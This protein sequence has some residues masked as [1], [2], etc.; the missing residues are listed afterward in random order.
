M[1]STKDNKLEKK[2]VIKRNKVLKTEQSRKRRAENKH[3]RDHFKSLE[4]G[5]KFKLVDGEIHTY[6]DEKNNVDHLDKAMQYQQLHAEEVITYAEDEHGGQ[7]GTAILG[8]S[9]FYEMG[10]EEG[11]YEYAIEPKDWLF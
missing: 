10:G 3:I 7:V 4:P 5:L 11:Y 8:Y 6:T 1:R 9:H 2:R